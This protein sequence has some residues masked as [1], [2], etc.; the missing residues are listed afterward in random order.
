MYP[1]TTL[2]AY[3]LKVF[4]TVELTQD[5]W[6]QLNDQLK[7]K[8][9]FEQLLA[10][11]QEADRLAR[12]GK[13][14]Y[15]YDSDEEQDG[16]TWEHKRR[17]EEMD[18]TKVMAEILTKMGRGKHHIGD[19]LPPDELERFMEKY[20]AIKSGRDP[21]LSDYK[22]FKIKEDNIGFKMLQK[23]GWEEGKG[24]GSDGSGITQPVNKA[25][26]P[27]ENSGLGQEK[28]A[29]LQQGD[30]EYEAYRKRMMLAYRFR[31]IGRAHV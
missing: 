10:K 17:M 22:E 18:K 27:V 14:K 3:A 12:A 19:F 25:A 2:I 8:A 11:K 23:L 26:A 13:N 28:P 4:G 20:D 5:H 7:M 31:Q 15:E 30:D 21:D 1:D 24:L 16:G 9:L 6:K 29:D